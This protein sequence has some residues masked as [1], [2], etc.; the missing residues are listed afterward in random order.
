MLQRSAA[1]V[2]EP[3]TSITEQLS[4]GKGTGEACMEVSVQDRARCNLCR[5]HMPFSAAACSPAASASSKRATVLTQSHQ[6]GG[7]RA[8]SRSRSRRGR[9]NTSTPLFCL[10]L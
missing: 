4:S 8:A 1:I 10:F 3:S 6:N 5:W 9:P 2:E 7:E